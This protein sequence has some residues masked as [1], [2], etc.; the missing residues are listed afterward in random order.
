MTVSDFEQKIL[1][2]VD[3]DGWFCLSVADGGRTPSFSYSVGFIDSL[4]SPEFIVFGLPLAH[5]H[6]MLWSVFEQIRDGV[7]KPAE[8]QRWSN[9]LTGH[10]CISRAVHPSQIE[11]N[12]FNS[13][14]WYRSHTGR[15][16]DSAKAFQM[17]WPGSEDRLFPWEHGCSQVV[18]DHQ[19]LL[20]LPRSIGLA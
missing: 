20:Y 9:I 12:Y 10:E 7:T 2:A 3:A 5:M 11:R 19:P 8:G 6:S 16:R 17:F 13:A 18:I 4:N 1:D 14:L 15:D